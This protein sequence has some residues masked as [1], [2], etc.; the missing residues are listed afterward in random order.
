MKVVGCCV[1]RLTILYTLVVVM[2]CLSSSCWISSLVVSIWM[3]LMIS[4]LVGLLSWVVW[5]PLCAN[6]HFIIVPLKAPVGQEG[7][8]GVN[9]LDKY[10]DSTSSHLDELLQL[11][12]RFIAL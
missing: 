1:A 12:I 9:I 5:F 6:L 3:P 8:Q 11:D 4:C 2:R 7:V 10:K